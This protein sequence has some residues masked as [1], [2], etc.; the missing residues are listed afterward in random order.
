MNL[1]F[2]ETPNYMEIRKLLKHAI[3]RLSVFSPRKSL[4]S[5]ADSFSNKNCNN[6]KSP[7]KSLDLL[8]LGDN[9][10]NQSCPLFQFENSTQYSTLSTVS[11]YL[12]HSFEDIIEQG[13]CFCNQIMN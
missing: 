7:K 1:H 12:S 3:N 8:L 13:G 11:K 6:E 4:T 2:D 10:D 5:S 9:Y